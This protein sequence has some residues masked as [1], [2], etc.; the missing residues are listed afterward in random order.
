MS[1]TDV[2]ESCASDDRETA[3]DEETTVPDMITIDITGNDIDFPFEWILS[4]DL[5]TKYVQVTLVDDK[6]AIHKPTAKG[7]EYTKPCK[8]GEN[9]YIRAMNLFTVRVPER[10]LESLGISDGGKADL[11]REENCIAIRKH[12][13]IVQEL[14]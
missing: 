8:A 10:F 13:D 12:F 1:Q 2:R 3:L 7:V 4:F 9:S 11:T 14:P 6:I 5:G